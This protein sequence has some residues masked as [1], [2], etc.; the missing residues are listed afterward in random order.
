M[1]EELLASITCWVRGVS[2]VHFMLNENNTWCNCFHGKKRI[3]G[4]EFFMFCTSYSSSS[5]FSETKIEVYLV[6]VGYPWVHMQWFWDPD[7]LLPLY[8]SLHHKLFA[9]PL[10]WAKNKL[11][12]IKKENVYNVARPCQQQHRHREKGAPC[13][14]R[15][16]IR[17]GRNVGG[18]WKQERSGARQLVGLIR[19]ETRRKHV[20]TPLSFSVSLCQRRCSNDYLF[21]LSQ[22]NGRH[23]RCTNYCW[24]DNVGHPSHYVRSPVYYCVK[25]CAF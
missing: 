25:E 23:R 22:Q 11:R 24:W 6:T 21:Q 14:R 13:A 12:K 17:A 7:S 18:G 19:Q 16:E 3:W 1:F 2:T 8:T 10:I 9:L 15:G 20:K 5:I 4:K